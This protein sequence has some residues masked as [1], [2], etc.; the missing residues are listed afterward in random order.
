ML[1]RLAFSI[2]SLLPDSRSRVNVGQQWLRVKFAKMLLKAN[3]DPFNVETGA[4]V[5]WSYTSVGKGSTLGKRCKIE[6]ADIGCHVMMGEDVVI[7]RRNHRFD[8]VDV[9]MALQGFSSD[10]LVYVEDDVWIGS[11]VIILPG[12]RIGCGSII[13][14]G[15]VV[16]KDV[17]PF[18]IVAGNPA[19]FIRNRLQ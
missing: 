19:R 15:S 18:T 3:S 7:F 17:L 9:P 1:K 11:R 2:V 10:E 4:K 8:C 16:T 14:A 12:I 13:G 6:G 5:D